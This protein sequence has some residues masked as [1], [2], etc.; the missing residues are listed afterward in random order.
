MSEVTNTPP[1]SN[2]TPVKEE[3]IFLE[4]PRSRWEE[5]VFSFKVLLEFIRGFRVLHFVGPCVAVF[6]SA[7][8]AEGSPYY[9]LAS[10]MG[11][12]VSKLGFTIMTG[13][14]PGIMQAANRGAKNV[15]GFSIGCNI[16]LPKEQQPNTY[17]DR[18]FEC[19]YFFVRKVLM[20]KYSQAFVIMPG[21]IGTMDEFFE[22]LTLIQTRKILDFPV[23]VMGKDYWQPVQQMMETMLKSHM[24]DSTDLNL[25]LFTDSV[26]EAVAHI[27]KHAL[28]KY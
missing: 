19:R 9:A 16:I 8:V 4:G 14:G 22:A 28:E 18:W 5:L 1:I 23:I 7:R 20:F 15:G 21:G 6:G 10:R 11:A 17:L 2:S 13:G 24:I 12:E 3:K 25:M 26:E 27:Q